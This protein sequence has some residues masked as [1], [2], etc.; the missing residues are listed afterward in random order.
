MGGEW[1][2]GVQSCGGIRECVTARDSSELLCL[3][4]RKN[5]CS[6]LVQA[7]AAVSLEWG[8]VRAR[9]SFSPLPPLPPAVLPAFYGKHVNKEGA[10]NRAALTVI[11]EDRQEMNC[12][13]T[14]ARGRDDGE[15]AT[16]PEGPEESSSER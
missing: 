4:R 16:P 3:C 1:G 2:A 8:G 9:H 10:G 12:H 14:S 7:A 5:G 15:H 6:Y 13:Q 11:H